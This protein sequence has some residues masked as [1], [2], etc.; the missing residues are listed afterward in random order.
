L[1]GVK[2]VILL[3]FFIFQIYSLNVFG[4]NIAYEDLNIRPE[5][6][7][8][9]EKEILPF[10]Q[11]LDDDEFSSFEGYRFIDSDVAL[12]RVFSP[13]EKLSVNTDGYC[14]SRSLDLLYVYPPEVMKQKLFSPYMTHPKIY[15]VLE[16]KDCTLN[17][18][19]ALTFKNIGYGELRR[20]ILAGYFSGT[21]KACSIEV[22][23]DDWLLT[24][25]D[26]LLADGGYMELSGSKGVYKIQVLNGVLSCKKINPLI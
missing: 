17:S 15:R 23:T 2:I 6:N 9:S 22:L 11:S 5:L 20:F 1:I 8:V 26:A 21:F 12:I 25:Y 14:I 24:G 3:L 10:I 19:A 13:W 4:G 18:R 7:K 16:S